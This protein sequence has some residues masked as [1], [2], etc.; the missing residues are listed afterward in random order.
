MYLLI[1]KGEKRK[2]EYIAAQSPLAATAEEFWWM[3]WEQKVKVI[4]MLKEQNQV[5]YYM[6]F[7]MHMKFVIH[8]CF[9]TVI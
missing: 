3:V 2:N 5:Y 8:P 6:H 4:V 9:P 1:I 7:V